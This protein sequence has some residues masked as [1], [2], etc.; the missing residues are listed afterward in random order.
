[1]SAREKIIE[2]IQD[3]DWGPDLALPSEPEDRDWVS[4]LADAIC[5]AIDDQPFHVIEV[6]DTGWTLK[7]PLDCRDG[8]FECPT[9]EAAERLDGPPCAPGRYKVTLD[10]G[11]LIIG[12]PTS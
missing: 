6:T 2:A 9:N 1:M 10:K 11:L 3:F 7:H 5:A 12:E 4:D 8:L